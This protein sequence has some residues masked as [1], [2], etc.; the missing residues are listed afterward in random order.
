M[1]WKGRCSRRSSDD[2]SIRGHRSL[3]WTDGF[4]LMRCGTLLD[5]A[6]FVRRIDSACRDL[7]ETTDMTKRV[8]TQVE[9]VH[10]GESDNV[11]IASLK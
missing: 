7:V 6:V 4:R 2:G 9:I 5:I 8:Q 11:N 3:S 10:V 1:E